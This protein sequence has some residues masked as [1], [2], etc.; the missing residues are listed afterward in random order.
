MGMGWRPCLHIIVAVAILVNASQSLATILGI[1]WE[2]HCAYRLQS[3]GQ[4]ER[5]NRTLKET[6]TLG[7]WCRLGYSPSLCLIL[8]EKLPVSDGPSSL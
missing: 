1:D 6:L 2:L 5:I 4:V 7:Y 3:S 8:G